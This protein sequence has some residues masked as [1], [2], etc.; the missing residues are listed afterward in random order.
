MSALF[1]SSR[2]CCFTWSASD[3][4]RSAHD[5]GA[6]F[7]QFAPAQVRKAFFASVVHL[8]TEPPAARQ[9]WKACSAC[10]PHVVAH[11]GSPVGGGVVGGDDGGWST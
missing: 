9:D 5:G 1:P 10:G 11:P 4:H 7:W 8:S 3:E 2:Q 6:L